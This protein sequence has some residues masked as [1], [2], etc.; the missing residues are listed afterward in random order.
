MSQELDAAVSSKD[1]TEQ[2]G[3]ARQGAAP[4]P[5]ATRRVRARL[6]RR[7]TAQRAAPVKQVLE[8]LA[9]IHRE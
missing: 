6:A 9:D 7:I 4:T 8:P 1:G 5:S 3:A 2:N